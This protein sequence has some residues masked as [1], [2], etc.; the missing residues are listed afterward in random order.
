M[1]Q[2]SINRGDPRYEVSA[3]G[4]KNTDISL[5]SSVAE[6]IIIRDVLFPTM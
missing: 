4:L 5:S 6:K 1:A 3:V 2:Q